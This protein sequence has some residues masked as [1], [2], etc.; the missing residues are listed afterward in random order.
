MYKFDLAHGENGSDG[1]ADIFP[2][3]VLNNG[4]H[5][6]EDFALHVESLKSSTPKKKKSIID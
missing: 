6:A 2:F 5:F 3:F 4:H 1:R